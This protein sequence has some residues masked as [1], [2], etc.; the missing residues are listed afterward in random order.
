MAKQEPKADDVVERKGKGHMKPESKG[1]NVV[2]K[3]DKG[4][5]TSEFS[6]HFRDDYIF[7]FPSFDLEVGL[8]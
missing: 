5:M 1:N 6:H 3:R 8:S 4:H 7:Q 2:E